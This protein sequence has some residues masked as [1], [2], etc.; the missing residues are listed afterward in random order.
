M[1][2]RTFIK[3]VAIGIG[4]ITLP[5]SIP[6]VAQELSGMQLMQNYGDSLRRIRYAEFSRAYNRMLRR[7]V[8]QLYG[9]LSK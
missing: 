1:K 8:D 6:H 2:R 3:S 9:D 4:G 7:M 5:V